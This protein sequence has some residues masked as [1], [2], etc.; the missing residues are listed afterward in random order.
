M[1]RLD[2]KVAIVTGGYR[3]IGRALCLALGR[4]G[5]HVVAADVLDEAVGKEMLAQ[6]PIVYVSGVAFAQRPSRDAAFAALEL[7]AAASGVATILDLDWRP[8]YW[9]EPDA[10]PGLMARA[11]T[12]ADTV[13]GSDSEFAAAGLDPQ[14]LISGRTRR[15]LLK[16]GPD[17]AS[18]LTADGR[19]DE[20][21]LAV[22]V[23]NGLGAGDAFAAAISAVRFGGLA[24]T[25]LMPVTNTS[26]PMRRSAM[27]VGLFRPLKSR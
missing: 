17:G 23:V 22:R 14:A 11:A 15:V 7:R 27:R 19:H 12:L 24:V 3:G 5:A 8:G 13:I 20:P 16:H 26:I 1:F 4:A 21:G 18:L 25:A 2:N 10:Y 9:L 6:A